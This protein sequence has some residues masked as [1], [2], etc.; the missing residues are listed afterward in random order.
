MILEKDA[1]VRNALE[2]QARKDKAKE[3]R[4]K[5]A[6]IFYELGQAMHRYHEQNGH[7]PR[8]AIRNKE[9]KPL[10]SWRVAILPSLGYE[11][12]Y[13]EFKLDEP[14]DSPHNKSLLAKMPKVFAPPEGGKKETEATYY[15][16]F[17]GKDALFEDDQDI[18]Y[19]DVTDGTV[20]TILIV[21]AGKSVPW[22]KPEDLAYSADKPLPELGGAIGD[23]LFSLIMADGT[24]YYARNGLDEEFQQHLRA[25][26][27]RNGGEVIP[28]EWKD[29]DP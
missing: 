2:E 7:F 20:H 12:L 23:G 5:M 27:T 22:T 15:Q 28:S 1:S 13:K 19:Q 8:A 4:L 6:G 17:I 25:Y 9:G 29:L 16:V 11:E 24:P 18:T 26:I 14:W 21:E 3:A 10:L